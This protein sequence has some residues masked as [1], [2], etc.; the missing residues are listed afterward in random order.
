MHTVTVLQHLKKHG[1]LL[2]SEIAAAIGIPLEQVRISLME[3]SAQGEISKCSVTTFK[4]G[5]SIEGIQCRI[6]GYAPP[7][8][9]GR[10]PAAKVPPSG[11]Q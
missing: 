5:K 3:L 1:Q 7:A 2:D 11:G 4:D 10:K 6:A 8:A 9:P